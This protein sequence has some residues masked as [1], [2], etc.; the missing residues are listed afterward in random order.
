MSNIDTSQWRPFKLK[1]LFNVLS[2]KKIFHA[3]SVEVLDEQV[4]GSYPYVVRSEYNNGIKGYIQT[5]EENIN[6]G[7]TLSFAQDTFIV[8]YQEQPY[9]TGNKIKVLQPLYDGFNKET[10]Q[11][12][13]ASLNKTLNNL[14]WGTGS[15]ISMIEDMEVLLPAVSVDEPDWEFMEQEIETYKNLYV[16]KQKARNEQEY[17]RKL[18]K[19]NLNDTVIT[20]A[21]EAF[22]AMDKQKAPFRLGDIFHRVTLKYLGPGRRQDRVQEKRDETFCIPVLNAKKGDN[23]IQYYG[24]NGDFTTAGNVISIVYNGAVGAGLVYYQPNP[25]G[26]YTDAYVVDLNYGELT[27]NIGLYFAS[28]IQ[29]EIYPK[30]SRDNK[31]TWDNRVE[32]ELVM[33]P[34]KDGISPDTATVDDIDY[35]YMERYIDILKRKKIEDVY[36]Q[37]ISQL[38]RMATL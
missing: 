2:S 12:I 24:M 15:D 29:H 36:Q 11:F 9:V 6:P 31:A 26:Q 18:E 38:S 5:E 22:I 35:D 1:E 32:N 8:F 17:D 27:E 28:A 7:N 16:E 37:R 33:F 25:V 14:S 20:A 10:A 30:Y 13:I 19:S 21:D 3:N 4:D 23:G 34:I